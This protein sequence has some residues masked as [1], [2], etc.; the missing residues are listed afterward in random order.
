MNSRNWT[1]EEEIIV[2]NLYCKIPFQKSSKMHPDVIKT[3]QLIGRTP[4]AV[5]MKIGNFGSFDQNLKSKGISGLSNASKLDKQIWDEFNG[6]WDELAYLSE[7]LIA[8]LEKIRIEDKALGF[9]PLGYEKTATTKQRVNQSFFRK[10]LLSS[11]GAACCITG[12]NNLDL[13]LASHIKPWRNSNESEKTN[14]SNGLLLNALHD[15]AFDQGFITV[16]PDYTIRVSEKLSDVCNG[17]T[18]NRFFSEYNG[19]AITLPD[20]FLPDKEFLEFHNDVVF[21]G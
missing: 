1:R 11:Y 8:G 7:Q 14:P 3:A 4:S 12:I 6:N 5:N 16:M 13:L 2:F 19:K 20:K 9:I 17:K 10:T 21:L 15:K 18:I